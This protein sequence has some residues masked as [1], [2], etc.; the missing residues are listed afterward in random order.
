MAG[1][2]CL[3]LCAAPVPAA[4]LTRV[5]RKIAREPAYRSKP[6][7]CL[8]VFGPEA[9]TRVWLV[10]D[11]G[12]LYV[13]RNGNGDLTEAG[14]RVAPSKDFTD[15]LEGVFNFAIGDIRDGGLTHKNLGVYVRKLDHLADLDEQVKE[16][17]AKDPKGRGVDIGVEVE[18]PGRTGNGVGGRV[19]YVVPFCDVN[20]FLQFADS[21]QDAP[22]I[23]FGGP[24]QVTLL[25]RER[26]T[27]G[28]ETDLT[29]GVGT[30]GLGAGT[31]AFVAYDRLIPDSACP[32]AEITYPPGR[33]GE[34]PVRERY[35]LRKRC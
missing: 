32:T 24:W 18:M 26:L 27:V 3:I 7:Y 16:F 4:D 35:E 15:A 6:R 31:T 23:H 19:E 20:G 21:P 5:D 1:L 13:D 28:L 22:V 2:T 11:G 12:T 30:P 29:L 9:K 33:E 14:E 8:L 34:R 17:L 25:R 10:Q